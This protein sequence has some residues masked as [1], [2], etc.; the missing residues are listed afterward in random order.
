METDRIIHTFRKGPKEEVR[1]AVRDYKERRYLDVRLWY[2]PSQGG[3]YLPT[4]KGITLG[5]EFIPELR[6]GLE[7]AD[8]EASELAGH[9]NLTSVK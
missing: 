3:E 1:L 9:Q 2:Q 6:R 7:R 8:R 5:I 4:K